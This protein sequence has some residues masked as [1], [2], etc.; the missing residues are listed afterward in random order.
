M[1][2]EEAS[3]EVCCQLEKKRYQAIGWQ[4]C[5]CRGFG[6]PRRNY[7][8]CQQALYDP[9]VITGLVELKLSLAMLDQKK[10]SL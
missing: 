8:K 9:P 5:L 4:P 1:I 3:V 2:D 10:N 6:V 7:F